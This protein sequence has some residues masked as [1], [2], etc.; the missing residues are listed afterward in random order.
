MTL[1]AVFYGK[2]WILFQFGWRKGFKV[3]RGQGFGFLQLCLYF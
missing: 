1:R 3:S 2:N